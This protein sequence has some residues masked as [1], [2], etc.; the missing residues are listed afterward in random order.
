[1]EHLCLQVILSLDLAENRFLQFTDI[2]VL[3]CMFFVFR[4]LTVSHNL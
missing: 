4:L 3:H 2:Y 1:M